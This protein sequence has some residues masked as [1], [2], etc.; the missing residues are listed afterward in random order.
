MTDEVMMGVGEFRFSINTAAY[1]TLSRRSAYQWASQRRLGRHA[2]QQFIGPGEDSLTFKG[3]IYPHFRGGL[4]QINQM[5]AIAETG[6][7]QM[8]VDGLG[9]VLGLWC[10]KSVREGQKRIDGLGIPRRQDFDMELVF[11]GEDAAPEDGS[12]AI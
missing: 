5:R 7:P 6:E 3:V 2:A 8:V 1:Q 12:A 10:I 9:N 4:G 11:Y